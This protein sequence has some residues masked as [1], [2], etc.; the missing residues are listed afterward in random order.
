LEVKMGFS[1]IS[2]IATGVILA[3]VL[4]SLVYLVFRRLK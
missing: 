2:A 1:E 4:T 3:A